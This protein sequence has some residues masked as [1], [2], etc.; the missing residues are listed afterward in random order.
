MKNPEQVF[1]PPPE[2]WTQQETGARSHCFS[3]CYP[4]ILPSW[5]GFAIWDTLDT[6]F[7]PQSCSQGSRGTCRGKLRVQ[8]RC[9]RTV[10]FWHRHQTPEPAQRQTGL[11]GVF[12]V[13]PGCLGWAC[14]C[15]GRK[16]NSHQ[17]AS[18]GVWH[19]RTVAM[20]LRAQ[21]AELLRHL[22]P[23]L[24]RQGNKEKRKI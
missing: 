16:A 5:S 6:N 17:V 24:E 19:H 23:T 15:C 22:V 11:E 4:C 7:P 12:L 1:P 2:L 9:R 8:P 18:E 14:G 21:R 13:V 3:Y 10:G 20:T